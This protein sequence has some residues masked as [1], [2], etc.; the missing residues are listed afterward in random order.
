M[1]LLFY[2]TVGFGT[3]KTYFHKNYEHMKYVKFWPSKIYIDFS[4]KVAFL[5]W[6]HRFRQQKNLKKIPHEESHFP[7]R[8]QQI[9]PK[10]VSILFVIMFA[11]NIEFKVSNFTIKYRW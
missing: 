10:T 3:S 11:R 8:Y 6:G 9:Y 1:K 5:K 4:S 2:P 7:N